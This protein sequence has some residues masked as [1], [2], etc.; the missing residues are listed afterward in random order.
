[1]NAAL[2]LRVSQAELHDDDDY[3]DDDNNN[4]NNNNAH[5]TQNQAFDVT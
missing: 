2:N 1:M 3:D 4:N 5:L